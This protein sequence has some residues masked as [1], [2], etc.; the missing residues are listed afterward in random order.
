MVSICTL[1]LQSGVGLKEEFLSLTEKWW[2]CL[3]FYLTSSP[4]RWSSAQKWKREL[5]IY[6][7]HNLMKTHA[8]KHHEDKIGHSE[9][10][11]K[12]WNND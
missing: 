7:I 1:P 4:A 10:Q 8:F 6:K 9:S 3:L 5:L 2:K 12:L 11:S